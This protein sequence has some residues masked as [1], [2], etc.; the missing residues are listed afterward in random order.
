VKRKLAQALLAT[1][2]GAA[3]CTATVQAA[4]PNP[5]KIIAVLDSTQNFGTTRRSVNFYDVTNLTGTVFGQQP[6]FSVW[7]GYEDAATLNYED[8]D[9]I[10]VNPI[11]GT[12]YLSAFD[13]GTP[14]AVSLGDTEGDFDLYR[15]DYQEI[16][17][18]FVTNARPKG[19]MYAPAVDVRGNVN[20]SHPEHVGSTVFVANAIQKVGEVARTQDGPFFD[21]DIEFVNPGR[22]VFLDNQVGPDGS[23]DLIANDHQIRSFERSSTAPGAAPAYNAGNQTGGFNLQ[24]TESWGSKTFGPVDLDT[25]SGGRSE[26]VDIAYVKRDGV[27]GIWV[28]E[29]DGGGDDVAFYQLDFATMTATKREIRGGP[30]PTSFALDENPAANT[31]TNDGEL[32]WLAIDGAGNLKIGESGF[33]DT[34]TVPGGQAGNGNALGAAEPKVIGL[35]VTDYNGVDT[36]GN[37]QRELV[38]GAWTTSANLPVPTADDDTA[39]TDGRFAVYD[40]GTGLVYFFDADSGAQPNVVGDV[41][42]FNP[43]TGT[44]VYQEQNAANHFFER[45]GVRMFMR[46]DVT[47]DGLVNAAD[48]DKFFDAVNDPTLGGTVSLALGREWYDLTGE[49]QLN[50]S[51]M[52]HLVRTILN[53]QYGDANLDGRVSAA[54]LNVLG[55]NFGKAGGWAAGDFNGTD[56]VSAAD[57]NILGQYFGFNNMPSPGLAVSAVPEPGSFVLLASGA[58]LAMVYGLRRRRRQVR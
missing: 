45:H 1:I 41:Y 53:T 46:G 13:S 58:G 4:A 2:T 6:L 57:L 21:F 19:T 27:E 11:N 52:D 12:I 23:G 40:K 54:D 33:F 35:T 39:V 3:A 7:T 32:D 15:I 36:N 16:L 10:T 25:P 29:S 20:V 51:D 43:L 22:L 47:G 50:S 56:T 8:P 24:T 38:A 34:G 9:A 28:G 26:P 31:S 49:L 48:I 42:V 55:A 30:F 37:S 44:L 5:Q 14:G 17:Q 18:D